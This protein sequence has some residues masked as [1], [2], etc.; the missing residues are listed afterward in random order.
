MAFLPV[1]GHCR[2]RANETG[3]DYFCNWKKRVPPAMIVFSTREEATMPDYPTSFSW[4]SFPFFAPLSGS[5]TQDIS[6]TLYAG[7]PE[8]EVDIIKEAGSFGRQLGILSDAVLQL[9]DSLGIEGSEQK[10]PAV[11]E[12]RKLVAQVKT[13]KDRHQQAAVRDA[14]RALDRLRKL[15][16][17]THKDMIR[18]PGG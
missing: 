5:V 6:P 11:A 13:I 16:P 4:F 3:Q 1:T 9:A 12:L 18:P 14:E 17:G 10:A 2:P 7:V 8:I 15:Y